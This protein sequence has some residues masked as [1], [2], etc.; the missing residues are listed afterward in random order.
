MFLPKIN[1]KKKLDID[2]DE[3]FSSKRFKSNNFANNSIMIHLEKEKE[4]LNEINRSYQ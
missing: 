3:S 1:L 2:Q 4:K